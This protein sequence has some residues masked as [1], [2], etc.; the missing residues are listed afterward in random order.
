MLILNHFC[1]ILKTKI[2]KN[3]T[4]THKYQKHIANSYCYKVVN[5][6]LCKLAEYTQNI[7]LSILNFQEWDEIY[8]DFT[9]EKLKIL[10]KKGICPYDYVKYWE[11]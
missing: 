9:D 11:C 7:N 10:T 2:V 8:D 6:C 3:Q 5:S 4:D 1:K